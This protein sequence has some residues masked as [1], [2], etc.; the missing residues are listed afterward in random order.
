MAGAEAFDRAAGRFGGGGNLDE[1]GTIS[2]RRDDI[3]DP[4]IGQPAGTGERRVGAAADPDRRSIRLAR[5][6][7]H[8]DLAEATEMPPFIGDRLATPPLTQQWDRPRQPPPP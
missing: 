6:R 5:R 8:G 4:P 3:G 1:P 2:L 7:L